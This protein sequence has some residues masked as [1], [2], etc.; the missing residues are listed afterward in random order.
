MDGTLPTKEERSSEPHAIS[1]ELPKGVKDLNELRKYDAKRAV[2]AFKIPIQRHMMETLHSVQ[3]IKRYCKDFYLVKEVNVFTT[4]IRNTYLKVEVS[5]PFWFNV[6][7][8][9]GFGRYLKEHIADRAPTD[10]EDITVKIW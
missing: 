10:I 8:G 2:Q 3:D 1:S 7:Y 5:M 4:G 6:L 9:R